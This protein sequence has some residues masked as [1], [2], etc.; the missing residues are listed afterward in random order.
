MRRGDFRGTSPDDLAIRTAER[1]C[2]AARERFRDKSLGK[3]WDDWAVLG[4]VE[5]LRY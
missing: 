5:W 3:R 2:R 1:R 4:P